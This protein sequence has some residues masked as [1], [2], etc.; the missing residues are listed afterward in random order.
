MGIRARLEEFLCQTPIGVQQYARVDSTQITQKGEDE[1]SGV[2]FVL[3]VVVN[4]LGML[5]VWTI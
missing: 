1:S 4:A 2:L 5:Q 3:Q